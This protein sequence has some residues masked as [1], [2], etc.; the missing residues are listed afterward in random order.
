MGAKKD[1]RAKPGSTHGGSYP[2]GL[3]PLRRWE[4]YNC[5][6]GRNDNDGHA[7]IRIVKRWN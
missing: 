4:N 1:G 6:L 7:S 3:V 5:Q 2:A